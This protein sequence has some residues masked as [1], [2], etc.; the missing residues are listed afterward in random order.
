M[1][2]ALEHREVDY[3]PLSIFMFRD[4]LIV[5]GITDQIEYVEKQLELGLDVRVHL[6]ELP[7][8]FH[9]EV[10]TKTWKEQ[11]EEGIFLHK[12]YQTPAGNLET[13]VKK[14]E[15]WPYGDEVPFLNDYLTARS[16]KF[17]IEGEKD[18]AALR[19]LFARSTD[20]DVLHFR[21]ESERL[22]EY[23][24]KKDLLIAGGF[25][26]GL[27][28][29]LREKG[30]D[31]EGGNMGTDAL[32]WLCGA[33]KQIFLAMDEPEAVAEILQIIAEWN[34]E[35]I[36]I[37]LDEGI[38][39]LIKRGWYETTDF[40]SPELYRRFMLPHLK[41]QVELSHQAGAKFGTI[42][43]SGI[44]PLLDD[45]LESGLDV[46]IGI[47]PVLGKGTAPGE[48]GTDLRT[49]KEKVGHQICLW[50]GVNQ[51]ITVDTG[52]REDIEEAVEKA[53]SILGPGGG[54]ILGS[55]DGVINAESEVVFDSR[56]RW[57]NVLI[58]I[59]AWKK[60]RVLGGIGDNGGARPAHTGPAGSHST[61]N[62]I[63]DQR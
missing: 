32:M 20:D 60:H 24:K 29:V 33:E 10:K 7:I 41:K 45:Y 2:A 36:E 34:L 40:W 62:W 23:A 16:K 51:Y 21:E 63:A 12:V 53:I 46:L 42:G 31:K 1:M 52:T 3:V 28:K 19:Y 26:A 55:V 38:D 27:S 17:L 48:K 58:M 44:M 49:I 57:N 39:L 18:V 47:D 5:Q 56:K 4:A 35:R 15:D 61:F 9:L 37:Y 54:F 11:S 30:M 22:K 14:T 59:E 8:R 50:G 25:T 13:I 43:T 6:P